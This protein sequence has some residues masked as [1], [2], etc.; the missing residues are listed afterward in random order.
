MNGKIWLTIA[1]TFVLL[2]LAGTASAQWAG[3]DSNNNIYYNAGNVGIGTTGPNDTLHVGGTGNFGIQIGK[4]WGVGIKSVWVGGIGSRMD[5]VEYANSDTATPRMSIL[6]GNVGIGTTSPV[7]LMHL[8]GVNPQL[9]F[10][11]T[12]GGS[13]GFS[14]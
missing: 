13:V 9:R 3:P 5:F 2:L 6:G 10:Q 12:S 11:N 4:T 8:R 14:L 1:V 7:D